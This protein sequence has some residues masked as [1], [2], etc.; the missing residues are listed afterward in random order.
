[1]DFRVLAERRRRI[2]HMTGN[3]DAGLARLSAAVGSALA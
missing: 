3:I 1:V 2:V